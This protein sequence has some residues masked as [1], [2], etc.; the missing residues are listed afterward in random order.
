MLPNFIVIGAAKAGT[1]ALYWYLAEHPAV[2]MSEVKETNF[3]AY[4]VDGQGRLI[5][6]DPDVHK[7]P[8]KTLAEY[9]A[10]FADPGG[11]QAVG[12]AS[13][14]YLECP[15][16]PGRIRALLPDV[17]L[18]CCLRHPVE[19]AYA[20]YLMYL[21]R[22]GRRFE[23]AR[24]LTPDA[25][26]AR[27]DSRWMDVSRYHAQL[28]RYYEIFPRDR[29][30]VFLFDD[31][32]RSTVD[33]VQGVY[34]FLAIDSEFVPDL[35]TAHNVGGVPASRALESFLTNRS[36][37]AVVEPWIPRR[38]ADWVRRIRTSNMRKAP[39]LP[40]ELRKELTSRFR[41]DIVRTSGLIGRSLD[42]WL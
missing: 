36:L 39:P 1:T 12:E 5:Y 19:R 30:H 37:R 29:I 24:D 4:G 10:L 9:E 31:L 18:V 23:P 34:R 17:R 41:E 35:E 40:P 22:R 27:P 26:W 3:F 32:K 8:V 25:V 2:F 21:W 7:F 42:H 13:P 11:A 38:A 14:I 20:D 15:Q 16:A 6:G 33:A 28:A